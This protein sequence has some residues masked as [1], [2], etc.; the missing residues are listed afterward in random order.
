MPGFFD[1]QSIVA[2]PDFNR[3]VDTYPTIKIAILQ[4]LNL[5]FCRKLRKANRELSIFDN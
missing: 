2:K 5:A 3:L 1:K 4:N